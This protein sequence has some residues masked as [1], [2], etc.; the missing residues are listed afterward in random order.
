MCNER[1]VSETR[2]R[3]EKCDYE[4]IFG[5]GCC[6][7]FAL[8][9]HERFKYKI[10][11]IREGNDGKRVSH[12]WC[13]VGTNGEGIDIRGVYPECLLVRLA[14]RGNTAQA[15]DVSVDEVRKTIC[16]KGYP[17]DL[18][19]EILKLADWIFDNHERFEMCRAAKPLDEKLYAQFVKN[20]ED[21][22]NGRPAA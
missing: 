5:T 13:Q 18:E 16:A 1:L 3:I 17:L 21:G 4:A 15:Y 9:L 12:V 8:R 6:F 7:H 2:K 19:S 20:I 22:N 11:G 14:N 10:R